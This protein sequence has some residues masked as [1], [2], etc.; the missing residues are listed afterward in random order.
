M[1]KRRLDVMGDGGKV[2]ASAVLWC[3]DAQDLCRVMNY[4][5]WPKSITANLVDVVGDDAVA[6]DREACAKIAEDAAKA[7]RERT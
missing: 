2:I 1:K 7:I 5:H 3:E 4:A 6:E